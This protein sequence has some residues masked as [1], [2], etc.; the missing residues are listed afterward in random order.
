MSH[1]LTT[2]NAIAVGYEPGTTVIWDNRLVLHRSTPQDGYLAAEQ[3]RLM[4][5]VFTVDA[6]DEGESEPPAGGA[7]L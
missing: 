4:H 1:G 5:R 7:K 3:E 6:P 2:T